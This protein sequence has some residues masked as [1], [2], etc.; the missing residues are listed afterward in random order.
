M[1]STTGERRARAAM[2]PVPSVRARE[3]AGLA[4]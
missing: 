4:G 1:G 3:R 2:V